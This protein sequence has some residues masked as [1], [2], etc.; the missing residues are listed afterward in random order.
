MTLIRCLTSRRPACA[1]VLWVRIPGRRGIMKLAMRQ[2]IHS[3]TPL[4]RAL[5][6]LALT[7]SP[8]ATSLLTIAPILTTSPLVTLCALKFSHRR[9]CAGLS[10]RGCVAAGSP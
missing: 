1:Q 8:L 6:A 7:A 9:Y 3:M 2:F 4:A 5:H 10:T